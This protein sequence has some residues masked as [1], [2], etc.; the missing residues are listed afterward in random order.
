[1]YHEEMVV[2]S[3][4]SHWAIRSIRL[5]AFTDSSGD[6]SGRF[7][8]SNPR[9]QILFAFKHSVLKTIDRVSRLSVAVNC[10]FFV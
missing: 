2:V 7:V 4:V 5:R 10:F 6:S 8:T 9:A 1:M 3:K